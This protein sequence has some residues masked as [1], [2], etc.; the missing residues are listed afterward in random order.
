[1]D[2][3]VCLLDTVLKEL[4]RCW[5]FPSGLKKQSFDTAQGLSIGFLYSSRWCVLLDFEWIMS[6]SMYGGDMRIV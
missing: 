1:M 2:A 6:P 3:F 5:N 4:M